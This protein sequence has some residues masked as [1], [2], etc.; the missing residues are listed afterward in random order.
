MLGAPQRAACLQKDKIMHKTTIRFFVRPGREQELLG[1]LMELEDGILSFHSTSDPFIT[2]EYSNVFDKTLRNFLASIEKDGLIDASHTEVLAECGSSSSEMSSKGVWSSLDGGSLTDGNNLQEPLRNLAANLHSYIGSER[3]ADFQFFV[4]A[5]S[6]IF[7]SP[8]VCASLKDLGPFIAGISKFFAPTYIKKKLRPS[9][10]PDDFAKA[11]A[12]LRHS[13]WIA[14]RNRMDSTAVQS[15]PSSPGP[16]ENGCASLLPAYSASCEIIRDILG[17]SKESFQVCVVRGAD[18]WVNSK[19][20]FEDLYKIVQA[21]R[22]ISLKDEMKERSERQRFLSV[23][24][25]G[26]VLLQPEVA[27]AHCVHEIAE[28]SGWRRQKELEPL[29]QALANWQVKTLARF[30]AVKVKVA[31]DGVERTSTKKLEDFHVLIEAV[32][33]SFAK[34]QPPCRFSEL[35]SDACCNLASS[36]F[37]KEPGTDL[38]DHPILKKVRRA[39]KEILNREGLT[40]ADLSLM[41]YARQWNSGSNALH[42]DIELKIDEYQYWADETS[43]DLAM[44]LCCVPGDD[45]ITEDSSFDGI[46]ARYGKCVLDYTY[47]SLVDSNVAFLPQMTSGDQPLIHL[48]GII[49]RWYLMNQIFTTRS[50]EEFWDEIANA[51]QGIITSARTGR[52]M[53]KKYSKTQVGEFLRKRYRKKGPVAVS[54]A[55]LKNVYSRFLK[56]KDGKIGPVP[57]QFLARRKKIQSE[58]PVFRRILELLRKASINYAKNNGRSS[59]D[60]DIERAKIIAILGGKS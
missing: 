53:V 9:V 41:H 36:Y 25:S 23:S 10:Y 11:V 29:I 44:L 2:A 60:I 3:A 27:F 7:P 13:L 56:S 43:A 57:L 51:L 46:V 19:E 42:R 22:G 45:D 37:A 24:I 35:L 12:E 32:L 52:E 20:F 8:E 4:E 1:Q 26:P 48:S 58:S 16:V 40:R 5:M 21:D 49:D 17:L 47:A 39:E 28:F 31:E 15:D 33:D 18:G 55:G 30:L 6:T 34:S 59:R 38:G 54:L 14:F 50:S